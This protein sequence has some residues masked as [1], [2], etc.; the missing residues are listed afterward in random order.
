M[1]G[2]YYSRLKVIERIE[3]YITPNGGKHIQYKCECVC[4]NLAVAQKD[5][6]TSGRKKS[7]GCLRKENGKKTHGGTHTRLY[8]IWANMRNRRSNHRN[9]AWGRYGGRGIRVCDDWECFE[10][11][12]Y[13]AYSSGYSNELTLDRVDNNQGYEPDNCRW[14]NAFQQANNKRNNHRIEYNG[15]TK[16]LSQ[17]ATVFALPYKTLHR[18]IVTLGWA[19]EEAFTKPLRKTSQSAKHN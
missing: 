12:K 3:D 13:W 18:R 5:H 9:P 4:G 8:R 11:F 7:C 2:K 15:E 1:I 10:N 19:P 17:W 6:L 14:S 16:T